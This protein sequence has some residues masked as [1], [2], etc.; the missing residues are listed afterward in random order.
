MLA[1]AL[2]RYRSHGAF[3]QFQQGLLYALTR[4]V[5]GDGRIFGLARNLVDF[6]DIDDAALGL[7]DIVIT[8]LQQLL[9]DV[10]DIFTDVTG[11]GQGGRVSDGERHIEHARQGFCKQ[12]LARTGR[13]DQQ[14]VGLGQL[15]IV[16]V[17]VRF[18]P[19]VMVVNSHRQDFLGVLLADDVVV[20]E[21]VNLARGRQLP[22]AR[23]GW[24]L[25]ALRE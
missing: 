12:G 17:L 24:I 13:A 20:Q 15:D 19:L 23:P 8:F 2:R 3:D 9:D 10:F 16:T 7:L 22:R 11:L 5:A 14:D 4:Y 1:T 18:Q 6:I 21:S 25:P